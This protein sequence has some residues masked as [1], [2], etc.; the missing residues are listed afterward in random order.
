MTKQEINKLSIED[1]QKMIYDAIQASHMNFLKQLSDEKNSA[2]N[3]EKEHA[4][5]T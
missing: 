1:A 2:Q 4:P 3:E 5:C